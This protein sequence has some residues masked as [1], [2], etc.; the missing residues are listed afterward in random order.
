MLASFVSFQETRGTFNYFL[1]SLCEGHK[2]R[3]ISRPR[4]RMSP[5]LA[6]IVLLSG[7]LFVPR[8]EPDE[9]LL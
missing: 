7:A 4:P 6:A 9:L 3:P 8:N 1:F 5:S 2:T